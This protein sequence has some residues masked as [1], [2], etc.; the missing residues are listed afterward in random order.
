MSRKLADTEVL[1]VDD[2][3][4]MT[5]IE[6][7]MLRKLGVKT[8][9]RAASADAGLK[10]LDRQRRNIDVIILDMKMPGM[11]G[12]GLLRKIRLGKQFE[13]AGVPVIVLT[14]NAEPANLAAVL[15]LGISSYL[16]KPVSISRLKVALNSAL[17]GRVIGEN[18][19]GLV[20]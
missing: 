15:R 4:F 17:A 3:P 20:E 5:S 10:H 11:G 19:D 12:I 2:E 18:A 14:G 6:H 7:A 13:T 8:V 9:Y 1:I 16:T